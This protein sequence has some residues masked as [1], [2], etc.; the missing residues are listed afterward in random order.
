MER[1][2]VLRIRSAYQAAYA[3]RIIAFPAR[4]WFNTSNAMLE[5]SATYGRWAASIKLG[6]G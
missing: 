4:I 6:G 2:P 5:R 1:E 3:E